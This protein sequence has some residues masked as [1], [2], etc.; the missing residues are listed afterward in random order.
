MNLSPRG[1]VVKEFIAMYII[2]QTSENIFISGMI[3]NIFRY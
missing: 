1:F 2:R 3:F